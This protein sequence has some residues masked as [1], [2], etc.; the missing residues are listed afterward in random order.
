MGDT[1]CRQITADDVDLGSNPDEFESEFEYL[2]WDEYTLLLACGPNDDY[3]AK[4]FEC[5]AEPWLREEAQRL[6]IDVVDDDEELVICWSHFEQQMPTINRTMVMN[7]DELWSLSSP[8]GYY[9]GEAPARLQV[10]DL[11]DLDRLGVVTID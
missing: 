5:Y 9:S 3:E 10:N 6:E 1:D 11:I 2:L 7:G 4:G 8:W